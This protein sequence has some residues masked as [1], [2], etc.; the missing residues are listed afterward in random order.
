MNPSSV[1]LKG[2]VIVHFILT[3]W[4]SMSGGFLPESYIYMNMFVLLIGVFAIVMNESVDAVFMF[5]FFHCFTM[6]QDI[7]FLGIFEPMGYDTFEKPD[8][9]V[10]SKN[11]YRFSLGMCIVNL[12]LK[13]VTAILLYRI[14]Q[15][16]QGHAF[17]LPFNIPGIPGMGNQHDSKYENIDQSVPSS[18]YVETASAPRGIDDPHV[19]P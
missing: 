5:L 11:L 2:A 13:P 10:R 16:R 18:N 7:I 9:V 17:D 15:D 1:S 14:W 8:M 12:I 3:I 19:T 6:I 4:A